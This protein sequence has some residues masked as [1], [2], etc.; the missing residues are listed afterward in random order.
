[1]AT[2]EIEGLDVS[3]RYDDLH[4]TFDSQ[5]SFSSRSAVGRRIIETLHFLDKAFRTKSR[6]LRNRTVVQ[7]IATVAATIVATG[8]GSGHEKEF[9]DFVL[10]FMAELSRQVELGL[11]ATDEDYIK[12][13]RSINANVRGGVRTRHEILIR[14][15][16]RAYPTFAEVFDQTT[17]AA[18]GV[19]GEV[20][21][22][23]DSVGKLV[24]QVNT[25]YAAKHGK[26]LFKA[27]NKTVAALQNIQRVV[28]NY[29]GYKEF[30]GALYFLFW[31]SIGDRLDARTPDSYKD[32]N[33][34][35]TD[36]DHDLDHGKAKKVVA[37]RRKI[38]TTFQ[39][40][41]SAV[42][43]STLAPEQFV[44]LQANLLSAIEADTR[45]LIKKV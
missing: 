31:E 12:F 39:K 23:G 7:S 5:N 4:A 16:L 26:D 19:A 34:L 21:R 35:R 30:V 18:S 28:K 32:V 14:K 43:P 36:L 33:A 45:A 42:T 8:R 44:V 24:E 2:I 13:Q 6:E 37:K 29:P 41:A 38:S 22:L 17:L 10:T 40:Y 25:K 15:L 11:E 1:V 9:H 20:K 27:T 3:L